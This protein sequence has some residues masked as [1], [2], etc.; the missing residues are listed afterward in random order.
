MIALRRAYG[1]SR[2]KRDLQEVINLPVL[3]A[4]ARS[5]AERGNSSSVPVKSGEDSEVCWRAEETA[6]E[7]DQSRA[8][9][10]Q[11][12]LEALRC[13]FKRGSDDVDRRLAAILDQI[14]D[15]IALA[16]RGAVGGGNREMEGS[17]PRAATPQPS[18]SRTA[19]VDADMR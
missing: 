4:D 19:V 15:A 8:R 9:R 17:K 3:R 18:G 12:K 16:S 5:K 13:Q 11:A 2:N 14:L 7:A 6:R 10:H 1:R